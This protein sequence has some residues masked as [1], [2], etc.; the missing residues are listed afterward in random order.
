M[1]DENDSF[2]KRAKG[3]LVTRFSDLAWRA[4]QSINTRIP[5]GELPSPKWAPGRIAK[6]RERSAPPLG[7]PRET[8]SLCPR[9]VPEIRKKIV[10]GDTAVDLLLKEHPGEI[11]AQL[12]EENQGANDH[13]KG[14]DCPSGFKRNFH[15]IVCL[16]TNSLPTLHATTEV[17]IP[18]P[19]H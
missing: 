7:F 5:E 11:K 13:E 4:F 17:I 12:V 14:K 18:I 10:E 8:D 3:S 15:Q 1:D 19:Q 16:S 6:N 2:L 9:C